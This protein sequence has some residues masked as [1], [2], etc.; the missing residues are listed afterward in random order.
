MENFFQTVTV[1]GRVVELDV[2][3]LKFKL[4]FLNG[5][6][7]IVGVSPNT[8]Y[9]VL[10]N[11]GND[12]Q[13]RV[14][15]PSKEK[16]DEILGADADN[17]LK[18]NMIK[19]LRATDTVLIT[20]IYS[21]NNENINFDA[22][23]VVLQHSVEGHYGF[24]S[25][26]WWLQQ[27][28]TLF[29]QWLD[30]LFGNVRNF[31]VNDFAKNYRTHLDLLGGAT[32][33]V[34]QESATMSRF[35]YGL[36][37]SYLLTGNE[38]ALSAARACSEYLIQGF[39]VISHDRRYCFW[40]FGRVKDNRTTRDIV[41]SLN[42]D[43]LGSYAL[44]EQIYVLSGLA[45]FY[46]IT[47]DTRILSYI[48]MTVAAFQDFFADWTEK[49]D[50]FKGKG[51]YFSHI[52]PVTMRP[53]SPSLHRDNGYNNQCKK[54]WNS[55]GDHIPA[56][57]INVLISLEP[58][59]KSEV[60]DW[61]EFRTLCRSILDDC[62][63]NILNHFFKTDSPLVNERFES[64]WSQDLT[65]GWQQDRGIVGHNLKICWNL[66]RCGHYYAKRALELRVEGS[67]E[68]A[69]QCE[70]RSK[71]CYEQA[72]E[73]G[74]KMDSLGVDQI[75][76]GIWDA[77]E[78]KPND[79][80][81][82]E[83]AWGSTKD[84]WQQEQAILAYYIMQGIPGVDKNLANRYLN[85]AR[86]CT[87][88]WNQFFIDQDNRK[89]YFRTDENGMPIIQGQYGIQAGHA[90]AGYH[91][92]ELNYLAHIYI[93]TYVSNGSGDNFALVFCPSDTKAMR[94][95]NVLPDFMPPGSLEVH[96]IRVNG[97]DQ[98]GFDKKS[99]QLDISEFENN[100]RI[101]V[102]FRPLRIDAES[103]AEIEMSR[104]TSTALNMY[105]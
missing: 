45:Q 46:R 87:F 48:R 41:A 43:D 74:N 100:S 31:T 4:Q 39:S 40:K 67:D 71:R 23:T 25:S 52:D 11:V 63:D 70:G 59:P 88:F 101:E 19:Y 22:R 1:T 5:G 32:D 28:N 47:Q 18:K 15:E 8:T 84:F 60:G 55:V 27:I 97:I 83:F 21:Q 72:C 34:C 92:F 37:S 29:E 36:S 6:S 20:G 82:H 90:I 66:T 69:T 51:G 64:D 79:N 49:D 102:E 56:Y 96:S 26:H 104:P 91:M 44:Y 105:P 12:Q 75:R 42:G 77:L 33:D 80:G 10:T 61:G 16:Y 57:L 2:A 24:E 62:V 53:D 94:S 81:T 76:G 85:L 7:I 3:K 78:R 38:R 54:N 30:S 17:P 35:L 103:A 68:A 13:D 65:W 93:R 95:I 98:S 14:K 86:A 9:N 99:F 50:A 73:L 58:L 89:I